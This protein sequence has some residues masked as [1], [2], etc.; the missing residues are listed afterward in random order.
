MCL[1]SNG[2]PPPPP[3]SSSPCSKQRVNIELSR[4]IRKHQEVYG[5]FIEM[6]Q[7]YTIITTL[8]ISLLIKIII[9]LIIEFCLNLNKM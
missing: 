1:G 2:H 5:N 4:I 3:P 7:F 8:S 6:I 9:I